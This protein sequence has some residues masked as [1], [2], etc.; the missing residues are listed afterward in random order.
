MAAVKRKEVLMSSKQKPD[1]KASLENYIRSHKIRGRCAVCQLD[2]CELMDEQARAGVS[3]GVLR[4]WLNEEG[5]HPEITESQM[6]H[7]Y[8]RCRHHEQS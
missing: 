6:R 3:P 2:V 8:T 7:H 5:G 4:R 1:L